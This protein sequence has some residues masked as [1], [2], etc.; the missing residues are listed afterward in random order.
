METPQREPISLRP[1]MTGSCRS[2]ALTLCFRRH[3]ALRRPISDMP[4]F[5]SEP[6]TFG[7]SSRHGFFGVAILSRR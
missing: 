7:A 5:S 2:S 4:P 1:A 6:L 3:V